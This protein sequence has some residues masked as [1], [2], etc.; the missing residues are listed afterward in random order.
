[1]KKG[2]ARD[3]SKWNGMNWIRQ[4]LRLAIYIRDGFSCVWCADCAEDG[5]KLTLD[6]VV[7]TCR[8]GTNGAANLVVA[9]FHCNNRRNNTSAAAYALRLEHE[10]GGFILADE[11]MTAIRLRL[12]DP[13]DRPAAKAMIAKRKSVQ[14][15]Q[16]A[17]VA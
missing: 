4:D 10:S 14:P 8:G 6:H 11:Y 12:A 17:E 13:I 5:A 2:I 15:M 3:G 7:P 1:M 9:C 16:Q